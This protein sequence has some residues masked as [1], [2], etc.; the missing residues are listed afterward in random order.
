VRTGEKSLAGNLDP[1]EF[2]SGYCERGWWKVESC[3]TSVR[4]YLTSISMV[5][6]KKAGRG[7]QVTLCM[8]MKMFF[9]DTDTQLKQ[10][11]FDRVFSPFLCWP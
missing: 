11:E 5:A 3:S 1:G 8:M 9:K 4:N 2:F 7:M 6:M 10:V